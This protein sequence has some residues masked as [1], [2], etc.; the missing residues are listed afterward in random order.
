MGGPMPAP[1]RSKFTTAYA[2]QP[3]AHPFYGPSPPDQRVPY[4]GYKRMVDWN[5]QQLG[6]LDQWPG[7]R[8][9]DLKA[10]VGEFNER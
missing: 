4:S 7:N 3:F 1:A 10:S 9:V 5:K 8:I 2:A 6:P